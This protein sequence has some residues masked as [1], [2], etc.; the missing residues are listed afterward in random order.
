MQTAWM[1]ASLLLLVVLD[2]LLLDL[3]FVL[4]TAGFLVATQMTTTPTASPVWHQRIRWLAL[5]LVV[6]SILFLLYRIVQILPSSV[7]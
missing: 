7:V 3:F 4:A 6:L 5:V 1:L 2:T